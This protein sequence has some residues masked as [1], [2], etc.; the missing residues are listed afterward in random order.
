MPAQRCEFAIDRID[1]CS[2]LSGLGDYKSAR[3]SAY[4]PIE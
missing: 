4:S 2:A 1:L 3:G